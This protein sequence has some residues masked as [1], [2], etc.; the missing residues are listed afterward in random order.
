[1]KKKIYYWGPFLENVATIKA[2]FNS[3][4]S[5]NRYSNSFETS[6]I[7]AVGEWDEIDL[8]KKKNI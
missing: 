4:Y 7:N 1:M 6:I 3:A 8:S 2:I 5:I